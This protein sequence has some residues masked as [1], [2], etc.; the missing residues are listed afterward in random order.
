MTREQQ[1][2]IKGMDLLLKKFNDKPDYAQVTIHEI[3]E[4]ANEV[5]NEI[6]AK[7]YAEEFCEQ[8]KLPCK[9][10][11]TV[12][13]L[14]ECGMIPQQ[15]DGTLYESDGSPGTATGYYC[16]YEDNCPHDCEENEDI[17]DCDKF[18]QKSAVFEDT[19]KSI[20]LENETIYIS[21]E[22]CAVYSPIGYA[23]FLTRPEA[24]EALKKQ[25]LKGNI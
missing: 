4:A 5:Y 3:I 6:K 22:N 12:Y 8:K 11:D 13:V 7:E 23:V 19:V 25:S 14:C 10:G 17:F 1:F 21:M 9:V 24:E 20:T 18:R 2:M 16:P 15:L